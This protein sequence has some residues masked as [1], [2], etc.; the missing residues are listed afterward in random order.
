M[1]ALLFAA[2][3]SAFGSTV[4]AANYDCSISNG[5]KEVPPVKIFSFDT[6][7]EENKFVDLADGGSVG[8]IVFRSQP[9]LIGCTIG[10]ADKKSATATAVNGGAILGVAAMEG[11][12]GA[13]LNCLL[14]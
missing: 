4:F 7:K 14:K 12:T 3:L 10:T 1:K 5:A 13:V 8:C 6:A 2:A 11:Q 9:E